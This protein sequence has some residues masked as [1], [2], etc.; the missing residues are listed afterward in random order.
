MCRILIISIIEYLQ[1][2]YDVTHMNLVCKCKLCIMG[3]RP[4]ITEYNIGMVLYCIDKLQ[5]L[6]M[7]V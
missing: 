1:K 7:Y 5:T 4:Y 6:V 3:R 2:V